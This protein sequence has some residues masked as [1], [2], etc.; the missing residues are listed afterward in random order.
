[1]QGEEI[2]LNNSKL[3]EYFSVHDFDG[4]LRDCFAEAAAEAMDKAQHVTP[5]EGLTDDPLPKSKSDQEVFGH[6]AEETE[7][8]IPTS[9]DRLDAPG[10]LHK[11]RSWDIETPPLPDP[12][13][14]CDLTLH[15]LCT[16][17]VRAARVSLRR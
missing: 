4:Y 2:T 10:L 1:M 7:G 16:G 17:V 3:S 13:C 12:V 15:A 8:L 9:Q 6:D 11:P 14:K 5:A